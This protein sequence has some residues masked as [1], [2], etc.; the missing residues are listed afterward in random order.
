MRHSRRPFQSR[1]SQDLVAMLAELSAQGHKVAGHGAA[2]KSNILLNFVKIGPDTLDYLV[3]RTS[4][5]AGPLFTE[6][7]DA[8][9]I[10]RKEAS[11]ARAAPD[12][13]A[14]GLCGPRSAA[15]PE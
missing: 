8:D 14:K 3:D 9:P 12:G 2:A 10:T 5:E 7:E 4:P 11:G 13:G 15:R 1:R 6:H